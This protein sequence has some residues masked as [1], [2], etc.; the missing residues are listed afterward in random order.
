MGEERKA[1]TKRKGWWGERWVRKIYIAIFRLLL[2]SE[3]QWQYPKNLL[4]SELHSLVSPVSTQELDWS[5]G[6]QENPCFPQSSSTCKSSWTSLAGAGEPKTTEDSNRLTAAFVTVQGRS[7]STGIQPPPK[8][9]TTSMDHTHCMP[10]FGKGAACTGR[11]HKVCTV[12]KT[13][14][15]H[16]EL[17]Y[18]TAFVWWKEEVILLSCTRLSYPECKLLRCPWESS[19]PVKI[20]EQAIKDVE[21]WCLALMLSVKSFMPPNTHWSC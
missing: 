21:A 10:R 2:L 8:Y 18:L 15:N 7:G 12:S 9:S 6:K 3:I 14:P 5:S 20:Y 4:P 1:G 19:V 16:K 13:L 17:S 11:E